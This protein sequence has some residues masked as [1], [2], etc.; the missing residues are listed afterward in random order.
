[1]K[2][3]VILL[4]GGCFVSAVMAAE[5]GGIAAVRYEVRAP[6]LTL[7]LSAEGRIVGLSVGAKQIERSV[8]GQTLLE[9]YWGKAYVRGGPEHY[10]GGQVTDLFLAG[11]RKNIADFYQNVLAED[12]GNE[13]AQRSVDCTLTCIL[14]REAVRRNALLT[15]DE[16]IKENK[17]LEVDLKGLKT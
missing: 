10:G 14:G 11:V 7:K 1:M 12:C 3:I 5:T 4:M 17:R 2:A 13:T 8:V 9:G 16:L 6:G 15:M